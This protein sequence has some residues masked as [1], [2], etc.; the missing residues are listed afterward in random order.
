MSK[1]KSFVYYIEYNDG[2]EE[3][4]EQSE[5]ESQVDDIYDKV[6]KIVKKYRLHSEPKKKINMT[7]Y[8]VDHN[9]SA[10][11]YIMHYRSLSKEIYG[12]NFLSD[13]D[14]ELITMFN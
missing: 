7:L 6:I 3:I 12:Y 1:V 13:F 14:I 9:S 11:E 8:T 4:M 2:N 10:E 5:L